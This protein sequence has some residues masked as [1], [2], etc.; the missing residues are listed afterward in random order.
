MELV[1]NLETGLGL[2]FKSDEI[3]EMTSVGAIIK[4]I[5]TKQG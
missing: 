4:L 5:E 3:V 1:D 2:E